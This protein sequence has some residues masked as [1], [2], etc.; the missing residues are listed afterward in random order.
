[1]DEKTLTE[2]RKKAER[3]VADM[4]DGDLKLKAFELI[5][6]RLLVA[7]DDAPSQP[8]HEPK[9]KARRNVAT[10]NGSPAEGT[11]ETVPATAPSR[12]LSLKR[13][14]FFNEERSITEIQEALQTR[15]WRYV[16]T[17]LSGPLMN[18]VQARELRR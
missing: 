11:V 6:S 17:A 18:L 3:A 15:G 9:S 4:A 13:E 14:G 16:T 2:A 5:L 12:I 1:M 7:S 8:G 10:R